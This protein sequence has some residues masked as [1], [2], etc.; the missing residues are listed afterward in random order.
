MHAVPDAL[1]VPTNIERVVLPVGISTDSF[2]AR[3]WRISAAA[4]QVMGDDILAERIEVVDQ[5]GQ[6]QVTIEGALVTRIR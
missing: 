3:G 5:S 1:H 4:P 2:A 6:V